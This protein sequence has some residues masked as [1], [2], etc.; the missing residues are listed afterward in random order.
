M[1]VFLVRIEGIPPNTQHAQH[2]PVQAT[3]RR[4]PSPVVEGGTMMFLFSKLN[5]CPLYCSRIMSHMCSCSA[6]CCLR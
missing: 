4:E 5:R 1:V 2:R 3:D 6:V